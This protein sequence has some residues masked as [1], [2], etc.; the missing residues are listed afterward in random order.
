MNGLWRDRAIGWQ[1]TFPNACALY[2]NA[3][4]VFASE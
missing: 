3:G 4:L 1:K 2:A